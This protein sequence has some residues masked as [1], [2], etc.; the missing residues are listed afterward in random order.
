[1]ILDFLEGQDA[2]EVEVMMAL[3]DFQVFQDQWELQDNLA[4][5]DHLEHQAFRDSQEI[6]DLKDLQDHLDQRVTRVLREFRDPQ[7]Q[8]LEL[9]H[10]VFQDPEAQKD[11]QE[12]KVKKE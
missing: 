1:M 5:G 6:P 9:D 8:L 7:R 12:M 3:M 4:L 10:R 2:K 11:C